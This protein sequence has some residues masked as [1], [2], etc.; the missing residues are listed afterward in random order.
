[1]DRGVTKYFVRYLPTAI[2]ALILVVPLLLLIFKW[3]LGIDGDNFGSVVSADVLLVIIRSFALSGLVALLATIIGS[4]LGF[5]LYKL[6][7]SFKS[8]YKIFL[9]LPLLVPPYIFAVAWKDSFQFIF[10]NST[11][12]SEEIGVVIIHTL[13]FFPLAMLIT[14]SAFSQINKG[15]EEAGVMF[16]SFKHAVFKIVLPLIRPALTMS[17][18]LIFIFSL[19]DFSV[20]AFF[21]V[22]T[23]TTE[24]FTQFSAFYNYEVAIGQSIILLVI[25]LALMVGEGKYLA[26]APFF[27]IETKGSSSKQYELGNKK[28]AIHFLLILLLFVST[29]LPVFILIFQSLSGKAIVF[30]KA[31]NLIYPTILQSLGLAF[32]GSLL[33]VSVG[34]WIAFM[35]ERFSFSLP[36]NLVL[37]TFIVPSTVFGIAIIGFFNNSTI[38]FVYSSFLIILIGYLGRFVFIASRIIGNGLKQI[39]LSL[40]ES[41]TVIGV[42]PIMN[43]FK[44]TLPL[45]L[46]SLFATFVLTFVLS[47]GELG[48]TIMV[49]PPGT[50]LMP[51][52]IFTIGANAPQ[53]LTSSMTLINFGVSLVFIILFY[54]FGKRIF[55]N[56]NY[57]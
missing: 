44:I 52:K 6:K 17:F 47:L 14:G 23:F 8:F 38:N 10:A 1:M 28:I 49:Y 48:T 7:I 43:F 27:A 11:F 5:I 25:S 51:I 34:L 50:E 18:V 39:P 40:E 42:N 2:L 54:V 32:L 12:F 57:V 31:W 41:A 56:Y 22:R 46:P 16:V 9:L 21:G 4:V 35:K 37:V 13:V 53:A 45:L 30:M 19:S 36:N 15:V 26:D 3:M 24:I 33:I 20:P 29:I 55:K